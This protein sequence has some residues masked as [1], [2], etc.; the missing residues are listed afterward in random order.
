[1]GAARIDAAVAGIDAPAA[2]IERRR[3]RSTPWPRI[4]A[5]ATDR[6]H[7]IFPLSPSSQCESSNGTGRRLSSNAAPRP[8]LAEKLPKP[9]DA[10]QGVAALGEGAVPVDVERIFSSGAVR[11][12]SSVER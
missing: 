2:R 3:H 10:L 5:S 4:D 8:F 11:S 9:P 6:R 12:R 7:G 1:M